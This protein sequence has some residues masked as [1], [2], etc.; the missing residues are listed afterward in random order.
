M[1]NITYTR[2]AQRHGFHLVDPSPWPLVAAFA[3][4]AMTTAGVQYM[5]GYSGGGWVC[6]LAFTSLLITSGVWWR[7][8]TREGTYQ[9]HHTSI[10]Q[11]GLRYGMLLFIASEIM[12]FLA[13]FWAFF[14]SA[15]A[16]TIEIGAIWPP[17]GIAVFNP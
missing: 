7:D 1:T 8:I 4:L 15:L 13:F 2:T 17:K 5:H 11:V 6:L 3:A 10:V 16:P 14:H 12:F 9:G